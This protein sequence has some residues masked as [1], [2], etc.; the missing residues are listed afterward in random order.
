ML[1]T[2]PDIEARTGT[3]YTGT[4]LARVN[5]A[6]ADVSALI[7]DF[8][9]KT[10][11]A[12]VPPAVV[13]I[14]A[15]E[16]RRNLNM[17]PGVAN[18]RVADLASGYAY[19]GAVLALTPDTERAL[20]RVLRSSRSPISTIQLVRPEDWPVTPPVIPPDTPPVVP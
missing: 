10:W 6:I 13:A 18:E 19:A 7:E 8:C 20:R 11:L 9:K 1:I 3:T 14:A 2:V 12:P 15:S 5:A 17:D 4:E 16:V